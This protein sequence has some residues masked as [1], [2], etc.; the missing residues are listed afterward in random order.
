MSQANV[1]KLSG[2]DGGG[3]QANDGSGCAGG[4]KSGN[5]GGSS[6]PAKSGACNTGME[7]EVAEVGPGRW[8]F[9]VVAVVLV[10]W[11]CSRWFWQLMLIRGDSMAPAYHNLQ[12]V[13]LDKYNKV[14]KRG[15][16]TAF[17]CRQLK[18][19]LVKRVVA[20]P[21]D[22]VQIRRGTLYING[23][24]SRVIPD[25]GVFKYAGT[26]SSLIKLG[27]NQYFMIGDNL[28]KSKDSR[29]PVVG[30]VEEESILGKVIYP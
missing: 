27:D 22:S 1:E 30:L 9:L 3:R 5:F 17:R 16:V 26:A 29:W 14:Y 23:E 25:D 20:C 12:L 24:V 18:A 4:G 6:E 2:A 15:D 10:S 11:I 7:V 19:V 28:E 13:V 21:G 8:W